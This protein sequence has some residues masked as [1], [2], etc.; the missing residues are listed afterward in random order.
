MVRNDRWLVVMLSQDVLGEIIRRRWPHRDRCYVGFREISSATVAPD[1]C[2]TA[3]QNERLEEWGDS[4]TRKKNQNQT[5]SVFQYF[6]AETPGIE[7]GLSEWKAEQKQ[8]V[9]RVE[10][11]GA[12]DGGAVEKATGEKSGV[13]LLNA[14]LRVSC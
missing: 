4:Q 14:V 5:T 3:H 2:E 6:S 1:V 10:S 7:V 11:D 12:T 8:A 13:L 9:D